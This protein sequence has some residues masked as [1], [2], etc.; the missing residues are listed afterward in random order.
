MQKLLGVEKGK[1]RT[2]SFKV[3]CF[4]RQSNPGLAVLDDICN[5]DSLRSS[6]PD[7]WRSLLQRE[8]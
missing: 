4:T 1:V 8:Q 6:Q 3:Q 2:F 5:Q 7:L